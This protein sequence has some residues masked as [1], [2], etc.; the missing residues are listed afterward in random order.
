MESIK[1]PSFKSPSV[2]TMPKKEASDFFE[3]L[4]N[5]KESEM[6]NKGVMKFQSKYECDYED[7]RIMRDAYKLIQVRKGDITK[8]KYEQWKKKEK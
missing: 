4:K 2:A 6:N 1:I 7:A 3:L 8:E 5:S